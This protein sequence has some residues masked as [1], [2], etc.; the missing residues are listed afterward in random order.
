MPASSRELRGRRTFSCD[1]RR[2]LPGD[3]LA[4]L[5]T[6]PL[7][8]AGSALLRFSEHPHCTSPPC[9]TRWKPQPLS[10][11]AEAGTA[12]ATLRSKRFRC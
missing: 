7:K 2:A 10:S 9:G 1:M 5:S 4:R 12:S 8:S 3:L 11:T 6:K